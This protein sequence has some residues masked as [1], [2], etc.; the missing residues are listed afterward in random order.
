MSIH[1][2][3]PRIVTNGLVLYVDAANPKS[4]PGSGTTWKDLSGNAYNGTIVGSPTYSTTNAGQFTLNGTSQYVDFG[5]ILNSV[6]TGATAKFTLSTWV[7]LTNSA[8]DVT[9]ELFGKYTAP[10][11]DTSHRMFFSSIRNITANNYGGIKIDIVYY[12]D[13]AGSIHRYLRGST[14]IQTNVWYNIVYTYDN[15]ITTN[16]GLDRVGIYLNGIAETRT[17]VSAIGTFASIQAGS[18]PLCLFAAEN[19]AGN[20]SGFLQG[21]GAIAM[22]HNRVL[23][24]AEITQNYN[25]TKGRYI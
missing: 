2:N 10:P 16:N 5:S 3:S 12:G 22:I 19:M 14:T 8:A 23:T 11:V 1:K 17:M 6:F 21:A 24:Q 18:T 15:T 7:R 4:Y 20:A 13:G 9:H 25:A